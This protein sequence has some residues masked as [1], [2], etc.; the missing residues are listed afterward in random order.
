MARE[1]IPQPKLQPNMSQEIRRSWQFAPLSRAA[2]KPFFL[3][4][5]INLFHKAGQA[6]VSPILLHNRVCAIALLQP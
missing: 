6:G 4:Q 5:F 2:H 3:N 1:V